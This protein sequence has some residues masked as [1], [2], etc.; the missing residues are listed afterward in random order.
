MADSQPAN[1]PA[2]DT[3]DHA[4]GD[5]YRFLAALLAAAPADDMLRGIA[6]LSGDDSPLGQ[7][8]S[9][10]AATAARSNA[11][12]VEREF[13]ELFIGVGRG[14]LLPYASFYRTGF[15][16][17][18]P[19][20][21]VRSDLERLGVARAKGRFEPE[22][23][24]AFLF[25]VMADMAQGGIAVGADRQSAFFARHIVPWAGQF[26]DDLA[27]APSASFYRPVAE[28]GRLFVDIEARAFSLAA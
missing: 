17:E 25:E 16:N 12:D 11:S 1:G 5:Q 10:L 13:F 4:R 9:V 23:H 20:A 8:M 24:V 28:L 26:F 21:D 22:D 7:A 27:I 14:E 19:L 6:G 15:L 2:I 18:R 3:I